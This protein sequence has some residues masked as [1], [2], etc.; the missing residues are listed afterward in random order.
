M[1]AGSSV[2]VAGALSSRAKSIESAKVR[3]EPLSK[4]THSVMLG[5]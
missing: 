4:A 5:A 3:E 1:A 2:T